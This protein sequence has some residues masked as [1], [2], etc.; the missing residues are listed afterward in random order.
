M[1]ED[2]DSP[3]VMEFGLWRWLNSPSARKISFS[4]SPDGVFIGVNLLRTRSGSEPRV[5]HPISLGFGCIFILITHQSN[6]RCR[7]EL[8][9]ADPDIQALM[10]GNDMENGFR[11][12]GH[13][14]GVR[15][16]ISDPT[17]IDLETILPSL[18]S[19]PLCSDL[20]L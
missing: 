5:I 1:K 18:Y 20:S 19:S 12:E 11:S 6:G 9:I 14:Q 10:Q 2:L 16:G 4:L 15:V 3:G 17:R 8:V 13:V 7:Q